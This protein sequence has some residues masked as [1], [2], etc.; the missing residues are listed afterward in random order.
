MKKMSTFQMFS[1]TG[2]IVIGSKKEMIVVKEKESRHFEC[3]VTSFPEPKFRWTK[4][5]PAE[6]AAV[7]TSMY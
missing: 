4:K 2:I 7:E 5:G 1:F 3:E 6:N